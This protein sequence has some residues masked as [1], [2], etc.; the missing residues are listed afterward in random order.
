MPQK[1]EKIIQPTLNLRW[2]TRKSKEFYPY[3]DSTNITA[4]KYE[5]TLQQ[6]YILSNGSLEWRDVKHYDV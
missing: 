3:P 6:Q 4:V 1:L 5:K 2:I